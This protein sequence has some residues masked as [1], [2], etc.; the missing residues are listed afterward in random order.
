MAL[1]KD[2]SYL[3][4]NSM[5]LFVSNKTLLVIHQL[6]LASKQPFSQT[7]Q[8]IW[9]KNKIT[10]QFNAIFYHSHLEKKQLTSI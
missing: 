4:M 3:E 7:L 2:K 1:E 8:S 10:I 9:Y 6:I 5:F